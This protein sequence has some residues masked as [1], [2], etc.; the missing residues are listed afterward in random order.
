ML[1]FLSLFIS[2]FAGRR[3]FKDFDGKLADELKEDFQTRYNYNKTNVRYS[4]SYEDHWEV[5]AVDR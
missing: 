2:A 5:C 3:K 1:L 4:H